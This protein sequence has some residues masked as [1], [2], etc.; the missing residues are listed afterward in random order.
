M[1][2]V[3]AFP[4]WAELLRSRMFF[5]TPGIWPQ[6]ATHIPGA[7]KHMSQSCGLSWWEGPAGRLESRR[8]GCCGLAGEAGEAHGGDREGGL[9]GSTQ[10]RR[11]GAGLAGLSPQG[12]PVCTSPGR[13]TSGRPMTD[14]PTD[15]VIEGS[16]EN[17]KKRKT[18]QNKTGVGTEKHQSRRGHKLPLSW[19]GFEF[20]Q[21]FFLHIL[22][23]NSYLNGGR[24]ELWIHLVLS[25]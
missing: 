9:L 19:V 13:A 2:S 3:M 12:P 6:G 1:C 10:P 5:K 15:W 16:S 24:I 18:A 14:P 23:F 7:S 25:F 17:W 20:C 11:A 21:V 8:E 22:T 4:E